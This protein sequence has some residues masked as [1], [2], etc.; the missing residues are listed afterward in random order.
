[1]MLMYCTCNRNSNRHSSSFIP[2]S[3]FRTPH[4]DRRTTNGSTRFRCYP[5]FPGLA[6][7]DPRAQPRTPQ[8]SPVRQSNQRRLGS[9]CGRLRNRHRSMPAAVGQRPGSALCQSR[10]SPKLPPTHCRVDHETQPAVHL[11]PIAG[12]LPG[13][14]LPRSHSR[15]GHSPAPCVVRST[16]Q[17]SP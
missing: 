8:G 4:S 10:R 11:K 3:A 13:K 6:R 9:R 14:R 17:T 15:R 7:A 16:M 12:R 1:M 5:H 2:H